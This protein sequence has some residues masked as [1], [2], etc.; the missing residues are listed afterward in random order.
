M[1]SEERE[2]K[3]PHLQEFWPY[4]E[5]LERESDRGAVLIST[6]F[7]EQQ[8]KDVLLAFMLTSPRADELVD[9]G[10][11]PLGTFGAR[12]TACYVLGLISEDEH[13]DLH[14]LRRIRNDFAHD[15]HT[16][17]ETPSVRDRCSRLTHKVHDYDSEKMGRVRVGSPGQFR[18]AAVS[19][20]MNL[21]NRPHYVS[22]QRRTQNA[23][24]Y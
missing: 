6:G 21:V 1:D 24:P 10:N 9:G 19:L 3:Y 14:L 8:L 17:F 11:A 22:K 4:L 15:I 23:W 20:I 2:S 7:L 16:S 13:A 18:T 12:I 5:L